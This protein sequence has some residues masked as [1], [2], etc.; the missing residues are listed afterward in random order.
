MIALL[1]AAAAGLTTMIGAAAVLITGKK[2]DRLIGL[3]LGFAAGAMLCVSL[4][5][6]YPEALELFR[7][8]G[9][10]KGATMVTILCLL[11]GMLAG[12]GADRLMGHEHHGHEEHT[13]CHAEG[14]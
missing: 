2:N 3:V 7:E 8:R 9:V 4:T 5:D 11:L 1:T 10:E 6:L 12:W 14:C 13:H